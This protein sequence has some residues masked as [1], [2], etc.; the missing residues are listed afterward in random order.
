MTL[1][2][3]T[4]III[5]LEMYLGDAYLLVVRL[6]SA[7]PTFGPWGGVRSTVLLRVRNLCHRAE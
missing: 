3:S 7:N 4:T 6:G 2:A 5:F 1:A